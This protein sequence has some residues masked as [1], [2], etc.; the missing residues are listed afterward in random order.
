[1]TA[2]E[3]CK[4]AVDLIGRP[5]SEIDCIGVVRVAANIRCQGTNWLWRSYKNSGKY[6][7][8]VERMERP[9]LLNELRNGLLVFRV[10]WNCIPTGYND[11]PNCYHVGVIY[12]EQVIQS[13]T[14][15]GVNIKPYDCNEWDAC[16]WL[17]QITP[18][19]VTDEPGYDTETN[20]QIEEKIDS[21]YVM[22]KELYNR[23]SPVD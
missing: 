20:M 19:T 18:D 7:Y 12:G 16:G 11:T 23:Y 1:M 8:L 17:K 5:Y 3:F 22:V 2:N 21:I 9:P 13:Q 14:K 15:Q 10:N 6:K 4:R